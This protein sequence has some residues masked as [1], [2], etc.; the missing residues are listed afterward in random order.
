MLVNNDV[1][2]LTILHG[3]DLDRSGG[4]GCRRRHD[5]D[6]GVLLDCIKASMRGDLCIPGKWCILLNG[7]GFNQRHQP[8]L[9]MSMCRPFPIQYDRMRR[10]SVDTLSV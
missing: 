7:P 9:G 1:M 4:V 3:N 8:L 10:S 2:V 5:N 6:S